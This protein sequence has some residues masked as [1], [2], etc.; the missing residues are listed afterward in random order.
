M[1]VSEVVNLLVASELKPLSISN[2]GGDHRDEVQDDNFR[3]IVGMI[4]S[5]RS[6]IYEK[7][8]LLQKEYVLEEVENNKTYSLPNDFIYPISAALRDG[9]QVSINNER[10]F[11]VDGKDVCLSLM[12]PEPY[13]CLVKGEDPAGQEDVS[14]VYCAEPSTVKDPHDDI[15]LTNVFVPAMMA[16]VAYRAFLGVDGSMQATN[17]TY[18]VRYN[19]ECEMIRKNGTSISDNSDSNIKLNERGWV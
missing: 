2:I 6:A 18:L 11:T 14:L 19:A 13:V 8:A 16:Y 10:I 7:F 12:F 17:N 4:N 1:L 9:S 15:K 5:A 3:Q